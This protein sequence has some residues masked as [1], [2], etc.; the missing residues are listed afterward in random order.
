MDPSGL[1]GLG[2]LFPILV[3][4]AIFLG[5]PLASI[6][7]GFYVHLVVR[8]AGKN[9]RVAIVAGF[10]AASILLLLPFADYPL[11]RYRLDGYC[12]A[13]AGFHIKNRVEGVEGVHGLQHAIDYGYSYG[14][15]FWKAGDPSTLQRYY[16]VPPNRNRGKFLRV[17]ADKASPYAYRRVRV[18]VEGDIYRVTLQTYRTETEEELGRFV[19]FEND[20]TVKRFSINN[21][22]KW[23]RMTCDGVDRGEVPE[24]R[25]LLQKTLIPV[26]MAAK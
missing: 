2:F 1:A 17:K 10:V 19:N 23:M 11:Q 6:V 18:R 14:E 15:D 24:R 5:Y 21:F 7:I 3:V 22:R 16:A 8:K 26:R 4:V 12:A 13:E 20:P 25:A 9:S